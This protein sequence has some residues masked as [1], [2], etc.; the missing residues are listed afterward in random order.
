MIKRRKRKVYKQYRV[1]KIPKGL[2]ENMWVANCYKCGIQF[3]YWDWRATTGAL[4][5]H[6]RTVHNETH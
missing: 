2:W 1:W 5:H 4:Q 6:H 3:K